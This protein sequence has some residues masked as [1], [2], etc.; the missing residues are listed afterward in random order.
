[1]FQILTAVGRLIAV[2]PAIILAVSYIGIPHA[3]AILTLILTVWRK[4]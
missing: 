4:K 2:V 1:M 3:I